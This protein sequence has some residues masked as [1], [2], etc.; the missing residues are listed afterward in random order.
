MTKSVNILRD[1][2]DANTTK[3]L[4]D[5][6][7]LQSSPYVFPFVSKPIVLNPIRVTAKVR[8]LKWYFCTPA[9]NNQSLQ[10]IEGQGQRF[11]SNVD[12]HSELK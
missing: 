9:Y 3:D 12:L 5:K 1:T 10:W 6:Y 11:R 7:I 4:C 8:Q 2:D